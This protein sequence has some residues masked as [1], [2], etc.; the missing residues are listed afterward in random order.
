M[1]Q[2]E[3]E[4]WWYA[5]MESITRHILEK[6]QISTGEKTILDAGCGTGGAMR[7]YLGRYGRVIGCDI[8]R[9]ALGYCLKRNITTIAQASV[10]QLPFASR[11]FEMVTSFDVLYEQGVENDHIALKEFW[12]V[13]QPGGYLF[14]RLPAYDW[15]RGQHDQRIQTARRYT[16]SGLKKLLTEAGFS[17]ILLS[18]ANAFLFPLALIKRLLEHILPETQ[19]KSDLETTPRWL[20]PTLKYILACESGLIT[21]SG[22]PFGLSVLALVKK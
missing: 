21:R 15:L 18:Y 12:R 8:S 14:L 16:R 5:G 19:Q 2:V 1:Y 9:I 3:Q 20:N 22:L 4:H 11:Q 7:A 6:K 10:T 13:L 17:I